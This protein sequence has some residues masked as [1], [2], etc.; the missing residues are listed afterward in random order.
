MWAY[1]NCIANLTT[2]VA[3]WTWTDKRLSLLVGWEEMPHRK[4]IVMTTKWEQENEI[5]GIISGAA[6]V[7]KTKYD[8]TWSMIGNEVRKPEYYWIFSW[9]KGI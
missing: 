8:H 3:G 2:Y 1:D 7:K 5:S 4:Q 9:S 6:E